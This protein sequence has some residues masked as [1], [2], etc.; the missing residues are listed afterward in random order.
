M[1]ARCRKKSHPHP[2]Q[3]SRAGCPQPLVSSEAAPPMPEAGS[4]HWTDGTDA[5]AASRSPTPVK[6]KMCK[7][8][9]EKWEAKKCAQGPAAP[10]EKPAEDQQE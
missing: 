7:K 10:E 1:V 3:K 2:H 8:I 5:P 6:A 9:Y 4:R